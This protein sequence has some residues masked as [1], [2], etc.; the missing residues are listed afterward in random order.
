MLTAP[1]VNAAGA[2][3]SEPV[4]PAD[5]VGAYAGGV[6]GAPGCCLGS[7]AC[8]TIDPVS[9][10]GTGGTPVP[11][12][13][14]DCAGNNNGIDDAC[15]LIVYHDCC[16]AHASPGCSDS[17]ITSSICFQDIRCCSSAWSETCAGL[18]DAGGYCV[19]SGTD[20]DGDTVLD[21]CDICPGGDDTLDSDFDGI[22]NACDLL[23][24]CYSTVDCN[25]NGIPDDCDLQYVGEFQDF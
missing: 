23:P 7:G 22:P 5:G 8:N 25:S 3:A 10:F 13:V 6:A 19:P 24:Y 4:A 18:A 14:G 11:S 2:T 1:T 15:D 16:E 21:E 9:C 12:C 17:D 20:T